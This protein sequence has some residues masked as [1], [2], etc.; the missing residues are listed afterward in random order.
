[1]YVVRN[2]HAFIEHTTRALIDKNEHCKTKCWNFNTFDATSIAHPCR[3]R[4][5]EN[6]TYTLVEVVRMVL[7][8]LSYSIQNIIIIIV[9]IITITMVVF[10]KSNRVWVE[11]QRREYRL[12]QNFVI[13]YCWWLCDCVLLM[14]Y[15]HF[16]RRKISILDNNRL[17]GIEYI[18]EQEWT[19]RKP[20]DFYT[21]KAFRWCE[22]NICAQSQFEISQQ[23]NN[24]WKCNN[25]RMKTNE[26]IEI[27]PKTSCITSNVYSSIDFTCTVL[28]ASKQQQQ[29]NL[30][31][32]WHKIELIFVEAKK[33]DKNSMK[34][35]INV[36]NC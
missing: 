21:T 13:A 12:Q 32:M 26:K 11:V 17:L 22:G 27:A 29:I 15:F 9:V 31:E 5:P 6:C 30:C 2:N 14:A 33:R 18:A 35:P 19:R 8:M 10:K 20:L 24:H 36:N 25:N 3:R 16:D 34:I 4:R 7:M 28:M 1:M 23:Q